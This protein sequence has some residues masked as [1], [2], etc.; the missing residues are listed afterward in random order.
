MVSTLR[1]RSYHLVYPKNMSL[2]PPLPFSPGHWPSP[3]P[4]PHAPVKRSPQTRGGGGGGGGGDGAG[5]RPQDPHRGRRAD[6][7]SLWPSRGTGESRPP[8]KA[9]GP[10]KEP[11]PRAPVLA[12]PPLRAPGRLR[13]LTPS[14]VATATLFQ[15]QDTRAAH[16]HFRQRMLGR[17]SSPRAQAVPTEF[18]DH[19]QTWVAGGVL[20]ICLLFLFSKIST[21][22]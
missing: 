21:A 18:W 8:G 3:E 12:G 1:A 2:L 19:K 5:A 17:G 22:S 4:E 11:P 6:R 20:Y 14:R 10:C 7:A 9:R 16:S 13:S 15:D